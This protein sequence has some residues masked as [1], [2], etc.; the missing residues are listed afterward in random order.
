M[1]VV[2]QDDLPAA[3]TLVS[4]Q[5]FQ[6]LPSDAGR[7][8]GTA[9]AGL[10]GDAGLDAGTLDAGFIEADAGFI[11]AGVGVVDAGVA[12]GGTAEPFL[13][14]GCTCDALSGAWATWLVLAWVVRRRR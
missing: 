5:R 9:D 4:A 2:T 7:D 12:D 14:S 1:V 11:D 10:E 13:A 8:A 6:V 3:S